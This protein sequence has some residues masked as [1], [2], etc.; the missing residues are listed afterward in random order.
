[1]TDVAAI[2]GISTLCMVLIAIITSSDY[3]LPV[4]RPPAA[5]PRNLLGAIELPPF[6]PPWRGLYDG[7]DVPEHL[8]RAMPPSKP[9]RALPRV[10]ITHAG[11]YR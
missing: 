10:A 7:L 3:P 11:P 6:A 9:E 5:A 8:R 4:P 2:L 1:M